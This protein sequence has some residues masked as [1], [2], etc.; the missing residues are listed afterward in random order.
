MLS[1]PGRPTISL[2]RH[3]GWQLTSCYVELV[4]GVLSSCWDG[5]WYSP[6]AVTANP[7]YCKASIRIRSIYS[8][9]IQP[10]TNTLFGPI[11]IQIEYSVQPYKILQLLYD[12]TMNTTQMHNSGSMHCYMPNANTNNTV[13]ICLYHSLLH[14]PRTKWG[15]VLTH[16]CLP[17]C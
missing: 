5:C 10:N 7:C 13:Y 14:L 16:D 15:N 2:A 11:R 6:L 17:L 1:H 9:T 12:T 8:S 4:R 3:A